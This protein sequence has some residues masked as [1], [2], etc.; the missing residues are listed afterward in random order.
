MCETLLHTTQSPN[1]LTIKN[2]NRSLQPTPCSFS[3]VYISLAV[4][5][6]SKIRLKKKIHRKWT[7][8]WSERTFLSWDVYLL[9][10]LHV[11]LNRKPQVTTCKNCHFSITYILPHGELTVCSTFPSYCKEHIF[12]SLSP[13]FSQLSLRCICAYFR[14]E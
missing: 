7:M 12:S 14:F 1:V 2:K 5:T 10:P 3:L 8:R 6:R 4:S 11:V 13:R 9:F